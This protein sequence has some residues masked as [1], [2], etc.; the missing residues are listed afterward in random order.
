MNHDF[1]REEAKRILELLRQKNPTSPRK[2]RI[3]QLYRH[4]LGRLPEASEL[5][6]AEA[7]LANYG[8]TLTEN[9]EESPQDSMAALCHTILM[10]NEFAYLW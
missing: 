10:S 1:V 8:S 3:V 6:G 4:L 9:Q 2:N 5:T 7:F